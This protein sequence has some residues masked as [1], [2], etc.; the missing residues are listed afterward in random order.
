MS[1]GDVTDHT[2]GYTTFEGYLKRERRMM[3][4]NNR[5]ART[6]DADDLAAL[7]EIDDHHL[8]IRN[9]ITVMVIDDVG[10]EHTTATAYAEDEFDFLLRHRF[11]LGLTT[12]LTSNI[13]IDQWGQRYSDAMESF[14]HEAFQIVK[15]TGV[16]YRK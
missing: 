5:L 11:D 1:E 2:I 10:K 16:D 12:L 7:R 3:T 15:A 9:D 14:I 13:A 4:L 8:A 6:E